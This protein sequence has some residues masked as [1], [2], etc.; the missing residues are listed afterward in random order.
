M[1][2]IFLHTFN[3]KN[4]VYYIDYYNYHFIFPNK[5]LEK[6]MI[7]FKNLLPK[8]FKIN[9]TETTDFG[10]EYNISSEQ[11][12]IRMLSF[13]FNIFISNNWYPMKDNTKDGLFIFYHSPKKIENDLVSLRTDINEYNSS[14]L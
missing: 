12:Y 8:P 7:D 4:L 14:K 10:Y 9:Y 5:Q 3:H 6:W 13:I 11:L 2:L 1:N